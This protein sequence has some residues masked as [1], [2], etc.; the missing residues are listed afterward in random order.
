MLLKNA[1]REAYIFHHFRPVNPLFSQAL[2]IP[3]V[4]ERQVAVDVRNSEIRNLS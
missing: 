3:P 2:V 4:D 1:R